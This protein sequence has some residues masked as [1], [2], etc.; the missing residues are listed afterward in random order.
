VLLTQGGLLVGRGVHR[1][2]CAAIRELD[3]LMHWCSS[4]ANIRGLDAW[5]VHAALMLKQKCD[6]TG[7]AEL[8]LYL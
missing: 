1:C 7:D 4:A 8:F 5:Q 3:G 6:E 2:S